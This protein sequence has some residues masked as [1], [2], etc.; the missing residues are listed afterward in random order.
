MTVEGMRISFISM[1]GM[2][3]FYSAR[4]RLNTEDREGAE[5]LV[6]FRPLFF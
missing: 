6:C 2:K 5:A 4:E 3:T 1:D